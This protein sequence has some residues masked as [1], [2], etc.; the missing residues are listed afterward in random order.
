MTVYRFVNVFFSLNKLYSRFYFFVSTD[1]NINI[2][3]SIHRHSGTHINTT[4]NIVF[5]QQ[6]QI[7][8]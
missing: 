7:F 3:N 2:K 1:I 5:K 8:Q 4:N 6:K